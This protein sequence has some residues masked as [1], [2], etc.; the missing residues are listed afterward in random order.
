M[1]Q[2]TRVGHYLAPE[3]NPPPILPHVSL[4]GLSRKNRLGKAC[5]HDRRQEVRKAILVV[6]FASK[7]KRQT[8]NDPGDKIAIHDEIS[9]LLT[10]CTGCMSIRYS[11]SY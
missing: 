1:L 2:G 6:T 4:D 10:A 9:T 3:E 8:L 5:L 7:F 11:S